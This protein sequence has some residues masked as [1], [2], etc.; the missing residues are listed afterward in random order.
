MKNLVRVVFIYIFLNSILRTQVLHGQPL[1][2]FK[3]KKELV[4]IID[5]SLD[6]SVRQYEFLMQHLPKDRL[7]LSFAGN[8]FLTSGIYAWTSGYYPGKG[9]SEIGLKVRQRR[10]C[11]ENAL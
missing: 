9:T 2:G 6:Q 7:P 4:A 3:P 5:S 8:Q 11:K 10:L 1:N